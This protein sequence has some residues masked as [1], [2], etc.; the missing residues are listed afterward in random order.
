MFVFLLWFKEASIGLIR[1]FWWNSVAFLMSLVC[2][3]AFSIS[4][5][6][7]TT[8]EYFSSKLNQRLEI[9]VDIADGHMNYNEMK[10]QLMEDKRI[11]EV[12]FISKEDAQNRMIEEMGNDAKVLDIF[13]GKN[14]F[15]AQFI[16]KVHKAENIEDVAKKIDGLD[17]SEKVLYGKEYIDKM[18][19]VTEKVKKIGYYVTIGGSI[20]AVLLVMWVIRMNIEQRKDEIGIKQLIGSSSLTIRMPFILEALLLMGT[21]SI[22]A[23]YLFAK[24]YGEF[25]S[26]INQE[27]PMSSLALLKVGTVQESLIL[28]LFGLALAIGLFGSIFSTNKHLKRV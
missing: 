3:V 10:N 17:Y 15:P 16:V 26:Y 2:L 19:T 13:N 12:K 7:G 18:L 24:L 22:A 4:F 9:Q 6:S 23:Y 11:S 25:V 14:I 5:V 8:A 20:F 27:L 1:N 21:S 28:P